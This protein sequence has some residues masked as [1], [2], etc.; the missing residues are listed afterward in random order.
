MNILRRFLIFGTIGI[1]F[2][3]GLNIAAKADEGMWLPALL[4]QLNISRMQEL[5]MKI[6][7]KDIYDINQACLKDAV[8][9]FGNGCTAELVSPFGLLLTNHHCGYG[10]IQ[11]HSSV[12]HDYL[13]NGFWAFSHEQE[14]P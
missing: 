3:G 5:G 4:D 2:L 12:E 1:Y 6:S 7:A 9:I 11:A 10:Q 13:T 14:L 8:M